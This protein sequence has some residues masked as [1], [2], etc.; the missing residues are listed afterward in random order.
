VKDWS[1]DCE[2][3]FSAA[4]SHDEPTPEDRARVAQ[5]IAARLAGTA[6][7]SS[8]PP[9]QAGAKA[10]RGTISK[11]LSLSATKVLASLALSAGA[12]TL[13]VAAWRAP[14][15]VNPPQVAASVSVSGAPAI[16]PAEPIDAIATTS[17]VPPASGPGPVE[18]RPVAAPPKASSPN[19]A[20]SPRL[21][22]SPSSSATA[23]IGA[24]LEPTTAPNGTLAEL[25][26][27]RGADEAL[28][29]GDYAGALKALDEHDAAFG[30]GHFSE[31]CAAARVLAL[32]GEGRAEA[33]RQAACAF[34]SRY[35]RSP[36]ST[37]IQQ[38]CSVRCD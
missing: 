1:R 13:A 38:S 31:E 18:S 24:A 12:V 17:S 20:T 35:P 5:R 28:R 10:A 4:R 26:L 25:R 6:P 30:S 19:R 23:T 3:L 34:F 33:A 22:S 15:A 8:H 32:C 14:A 11:G 2:S 36:M 7:V 37:R 21:P 9:A 27:V 29:R 16:A